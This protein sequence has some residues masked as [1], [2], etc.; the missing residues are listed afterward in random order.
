MICAPSG[1]EGGRGWG[2]TSGH[3]PLLADGHWR[4]FLPPLPT[5]RAYCI[6][7]A[8]GGGPSPAGGGPP[9]PPASPLL[10]STPAKRLPPPPPL[11]PTHPL[12]L[13]VRRPRAQCRVAPVAN[14]R[15][16]ATGTLR[17]S[18]KP[19]AGTA[20][21]QPRGCHTPRGGSGNAAS[22]PPPSLFPG[23][24]AYCNGKGT[25]CP[26]GPLRCPPYV[27]PVRCPHPAYTPPVTD[28]LL[29]SVLETPQG[30][31]SMDAPPCGLPLLHGPRTLGG[32]RRTRRAPA[33]PRMLLA[34]VG[35]CDGA[36]AASR[37]TMG[38]HRGR[39]APPAGKEAAVR[40]RAKE[41]G[42]HRTQM[43]VGERGATL[44]IICRFV[45][46]VPG[47]R[48]CERRYRTCAGWKS[49]GEG[50]E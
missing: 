30:G 15:S 4:F 14:S 24:K 12:P 43:G 36:Y 47:G 44:G 2:G 6:H 38:R 41:S 22:P 27:G 48:V 50:E 8:S 46:V 28:P 37:G 21:R 45:T 9:R 23:Q 35:R 18:A 17:G 20:Q 13:C 40:V 10:L 19:A 32:S 29:P 16:K 11:P 7:A 49:V 26:P 5:Q 42:G 3:R 1:R 39:N 33:P 25:P 31:V 34:C